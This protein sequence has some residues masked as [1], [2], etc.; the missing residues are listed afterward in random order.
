MCS[1]APE[2]VGDEYET[3][4]IVDLIEVMKKFRDKT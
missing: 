3:P 4:D 2:V 1:H